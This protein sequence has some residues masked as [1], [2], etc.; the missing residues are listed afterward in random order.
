MN[1][2]DIVRRGYDKVSYVYRSEDRDAFSHD[3]MSWLA[4]LIPLLAPESEILDL[5]CGCGIPV[6]QALSKDFVVTGVDISPVQIERAKNMAPQAEFICADMTEIDFPARSFSAIVS[7]YAIIHIPLAEQP[8]LFKK[9]HVWLK[10]E[11]YLLVTVGTKDWTGTEE[12][13][14]G[15][16][17]ATMYWSHAD[18][19]TYRKWLAELNFEICQ[20][21]FVPEGDGGNTL[22]LAR[23]S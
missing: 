21:Q 14:L 18:L 1:S 9:L 8:D 2:K 11:G 16:P 6:S 4:K 23:K 19:E 17:D 22:I 15:V 13:W 20:M 10:P 7:F 12:N 5:G 3:Y